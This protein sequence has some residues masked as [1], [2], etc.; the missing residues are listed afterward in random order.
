[1]S[2]RNLALRMAARRVGG[3]FI[4]GGPM[5][6]RFRG[7]GLYG[8][9]YYRNKRGVW[10]R[11]TWNGN[12]DPVQGQVSADFYARLKNQW[13]DNFRDE[14]DPPEG[15]YEVGP[16]RERSD[17]QLYLKRYWSVPMTG[18]KGAERQRAFVGEIQ[19]LSNQ[20]RA[21]G[22]AK[23]PKKPKWSATGRAARAK[24]TYRLKYPDFPY[25]TSAYEW[26][27]PAYGPRNVL[28]PR[29]R[30]TYNV[31]QV[32]DPFEG[33]EDYDPFGYTP[34]KRYKQDYS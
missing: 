29:P 7:S 1:M 15:Y 23:G 30:P 17:W 9:F 28:G 25:S 33:E 22:L 5:G 2:S 3:G 6:G 24:G 11:R 34:N 27:K 26:S 10:N 21:E 18:L 12:L 31:A 19:R 8:G 32:W 14:G 20:Y 13:K 16:K 4:G